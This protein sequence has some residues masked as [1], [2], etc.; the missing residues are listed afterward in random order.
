MNIYMYGGLHYQTYTK[1]TASCLYP[2]I[3]HAGENV[4]QEAWL[5]ILQ[6]Y[7]DLNSEL[8][9]VIETGVSHDETL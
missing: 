3:A 4:L 8:D 5:V 7:K 2:G 6:V 9:N 1:F